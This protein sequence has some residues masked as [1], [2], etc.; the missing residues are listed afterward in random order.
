MGGC[1]KEHMT[2]D[3]RPKCERRCVGEIIE[4]YK[5]YD[6]CCREIVK[7]CSICGYEYEAHKHHMC[8]RCRGYGHMGYGHGYCH[9]MG[10]DGYY[11]HG[12]MGHYGHM[13]YGRD[14]EMYRYKK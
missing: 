12:Y 2:H 14:G 7:V 6:T 8:P 5:V 1:C 9:E 3:C 4:K 10:Y 13:G 11:G